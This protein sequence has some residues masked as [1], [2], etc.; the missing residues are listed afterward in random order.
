[1][2]E[3]VY[4]TAEISRREEQRTKMASQ[5]TSDV[6]SLKETCMNS[7]KDIY[8]TFAHIKFLKVVIDSQM[9]FGSSDDFIV[10]VVKV[11]KGR[12][13]KIHTGLIGAFAEKSKKEFYGTKE[14]LNDSEDFF[15]Y[16]FALIEFP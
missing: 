2:R 12:E 11:V 8:S 7:F 16:A 5:A 6:D 4:D 3:F 13:K 14:E 1:M 9:R 10:L 15:P